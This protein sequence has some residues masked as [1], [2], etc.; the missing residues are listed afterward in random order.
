MR[1]TGARK[2]ARGE[3]LPREKRD[4]AAAILAGGIVAPAVQRYLA[5]LSE[6]LIDTGGLYFLDPAI[7]PMTS[8][9]F[10]PQPQVATLISRTVHIGRQ[11]AR[12]AGQPTYRGPC[13]IIACDRQTADFLEA[14]A[15]GNSSDAPPLAPMQRILL[16]ATVAAPP[17][18]LEDGDVRLPDGRH[19]WLAAEVARSR[20]C[21][22]K[23]QRGP[24]RH[25]IDHF[26]RHGFALT[27]T[28]D[29]GRSREAM[30]AS[31]DSPVRKGNL[32]KE[33]RVRR[34]RFASNPELLSTLVG[35]VNGHLENFR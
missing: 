8:P 2:S 6:A 34:A 15:R 22:G 3:L 35:A 24:A 20:M 18:L 7:D 27:K 11:A 13:T 12:L 26:L 25:V 4:I 23:Q 31:A 30:A 17:N 28:V 9:F 19:S 32:T 14:F 10:A 29:W 16:A 21:A 1:I 33:A 5:S